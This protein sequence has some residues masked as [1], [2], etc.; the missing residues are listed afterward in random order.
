MAR[1][2]KKLKFCIICDEYFSS[3]Q[4][5]RKHMA[6]KH[7]KLKPFKCN[8]CRMSFQQKDNLEKHV[9]KNHLPDKTLDIKQKNQ[10]VE[11]SDVEILSES[12]ND[13]AKDKAND[14]EAEGGSVMIV[15]E[16]KA[17]NKTSEKGTIQI[18]RNQEGGREG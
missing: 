2:H 8:K 13:K 17:A 9:I 18:L 16:V 3:Q 4:D 5:F 1:I 11:T 6:E 7:Q 14:V 10:V 12:Q 15:H